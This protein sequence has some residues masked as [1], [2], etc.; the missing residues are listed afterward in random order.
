MKL[1][2]KKEIKLRFH[3]TLYFIL[4]MRCTS[5]FETSL[6]TSFFFGPQI[7][8]KKERHK[9][10]YTVLKLCIVHQEELKICIDNFKCIPSIHCIIMLVM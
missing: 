1:N 8:T 6:N 9:N 10:K 4:S 7:I 3:I 2:C 5:K